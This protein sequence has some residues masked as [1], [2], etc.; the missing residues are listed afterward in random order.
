YRTVSPPISSPPRGRRPTSLRIRVPSL[1]APQ[2]LWLLVLACISTILCNNPH[3]PYKWTWVI[4]NP[5]I[6]HNIVLATQEGPQIWFPDLQFDLCHSDG[7][8]GPPC[9]MDTWYIC[10]GESRPPECGSSAEYY[11]KQW[12]CET[13]VGGSRA[14]KVAKDDL[15]KYSRPHNQNSWIQARFTPKGKEAQGWEQGK[16][17]GIRLYWIG[18]S[19]E[20]LIFTLKVL[21]TQIVPAVVGPNKALAPPPSANTPIMPEST[22]VPKTIQ[23]IPEER[24]LNSPPE[25]PNLL[26]PGISEENAL[27]APLWKLLL[28][29]YDVVNK[30][31]PQMTESCWMCYDMQLP[32]YEGIALPGSY[33]LTSKV[34]D[35]RWEPVESGLTLEKVIGKGSCVGNPPPSLQHLCNQTSPI[36]TQMTYLLPSENSWWACDTGLTP[37]A[38][39]AMLNR[40]HGFCVMV[41]LV[42]RLI[43]HSEEEVIFRLENKELQRKVKG[44][45]AVAIL[46]IG[47]LLGTVGVGTGTT[48]LI[49][50][51]SYFSSLREAIDED[52]QELQR[53][54]KHLEELHA[55]LA[56][57]VL[58][59]RRGLDL[60]FLQQGGLCAA[61]GEECCFYVNHSGVIRQSI[62]KVQ[63]GLEKRRKERERQKGWFESWFDYSPWLTTLLSALVGPLLVIMLALIVGPCIINKFAAFVKERINTVQLMVLRAQYQSLDKSSRVEP[64][65][66]T[67]RNP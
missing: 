25:L 56:E 11:C 41:Q 42:P 61:L 65:E 19:D 53:Q 16:S 4:Q 3:F 31:Q 12:G 45:V 46:T 23:R 44:E 36:P 62:A 38:H 64:Y 67:Q 52:I 30:T 10:P 35:C 17:W 43:Y 39:T 14:W 66:L 54:V 8:N 24:D 7:L 28:K 58:Q 48:A 34:Q 51:R 9:K 20:G 57:I 6:G 33:T 63:E 21:K 1:C 49:E 29:T 22:Q 50:Q 26:V 27:G 60:V 5:A 59:N 32:F 13:S 55:S 15:V 40:T 47:A 37:C 18:S 2:I